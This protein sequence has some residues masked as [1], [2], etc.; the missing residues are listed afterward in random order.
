M[1]GRERIPATISPAG[2]ERLG[3]PKG[4]VFVDPPER[5]DGQW[6]TPAVYNGSGKRIAEHTETDEEGN[7][8]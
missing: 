4:P 5:F 8:T 7:I 2:R 3:H 6:M 1:A